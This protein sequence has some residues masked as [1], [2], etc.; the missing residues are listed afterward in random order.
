M[1]FVR[2]LVLR[3][4][5]AGAV[6]IALSIAVPIA[7]ATHQGTARTVDSPVAETVTLPMNHW[8]AYTMTLSEFESID[9]NILVTNGTAIDVYFVPATELANYANDSASSFQYYREN[10]NNTLNARGTFGRATGAISVIIDNVGIVPGD[11]QPTGSVTVSVDLTKTSNGSNLFLGA[12]IFIG[13]GVLFLV[14][15]VV[16]FLVLRRRKAAA[17]PPPPTP[18]TT[19][20]RPYERPPANAPSDRPE[21]P[22]RDGPPPPSPPQG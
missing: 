15:A 10:T 16:V 2:S 7:G 20:P 13:C 3:L 9:Y 12:Y 22:A 19:P 21:G 6:V 17:G 14:V 8:T 4:A 11:A 18:Y 1:K 5:I